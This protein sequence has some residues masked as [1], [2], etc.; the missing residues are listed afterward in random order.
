MINNYCDIQNNQG[1]G[2]GYQMKPQVEADNLYRD[3]DY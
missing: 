1:R 2:R 3:L